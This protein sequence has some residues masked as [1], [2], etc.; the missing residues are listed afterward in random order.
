[1]VSRQ[2]RYQVEVEWTGNLG[3]G[4]S[5]Y[6]SYT[7]ALALRSPGRPTI[8]GSSDPAFRG[9]ETRWN[10]EQLL[11][12][13][14]A[15]CHQLSYLHLC[16]VAG[17]IVIAYLDQ[18]EGFMDETNDGAGQFVRVV[19]RPRVT[20]AAGSDVTLALR[21]HHDAGEKCF[22]ARSVNFPVLHEPSVL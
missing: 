18:A 7:R 8:L 1:M 17:V 15:M 14:L 19:L 10:P 4:T 11:L 16:S 21:L 3:S 13:S 12:A 20:V 9:D 22:I 5:S 6:R 2:H